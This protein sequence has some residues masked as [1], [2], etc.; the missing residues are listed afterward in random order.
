MS[1]QTEDGTGKGGIADLVAAKDGAAGKVQ[2]NEIPPTGAKPEITENDPIEHYRRP[3][4]SVNGSRSVIIGETDGMTELFRYV[5]QLARLPTTVLIRGESGTGKELFAKALHY[6]GNRA[7]KN[8]FAVNC[9]GI[10]SE[11]LESELFGY[12]RGAF[13][14]A[15][16]DQQGKFEYADGGTI[17]LD[18][19]GDLSPVLQAKILR[20]LQERE[21]TPL[22]GNE[23]RKV[24]TRVVAAT[25]RNLE[26]MVEKGDFRQDLY[27]RLDVAQIDVPPLRE[28]RKDIPL[29]TEYFIGRFNEIY[30]ANILG[31]TEEA[32]EVLMLHEWKGNVRELENA[33]ERAFVERSNGNILLGDLRLTVHAPTAQNSVRAAPY[34][35]GSAVAGTG[36]LW[37]EDGVLPINLSDLSMIS[38]QRYAKLQRRSI[39]GTVY[40][41]HEIG[42]FFL[43]PFNLGVFVEN[44]SVHYKT[45][46][47]EIKNGRFNEIVLNPFRLFTATSMRRSGLGCTHDTTLHKKISQTGVYQTG[48]VKKVFAV[49][50]SNARYFVPPTAP[51]YEQRVNGMIEQVQQYYTSFKQWNPNVSQ[52]SSPLHQI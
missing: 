25:N 5:N 43:T 2:G 46:M 21:I 13:S 45:L 1:G 3:R 44:G 16:R 18:E 37:Y 52:N 10:P 36:R 15:H 12:K 28:R 19:I 51:D 42:I 32:R 20:V 38:G 22:G 41:D 17:F 9:A 6:N 30:C 23:T 24:N 29:I 7:H 27:Y 8:F 14:G 26:Q 48:S 47:A 11:L 31:M 35:S 49:T 40:F 4:Y 33:V 39:N 34:D 50:E